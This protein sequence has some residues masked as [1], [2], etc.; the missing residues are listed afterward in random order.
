MT[1]QY[2]T[3]PLTPGDGALMGLSLALTVYGFAIVVAST[4]ADKELVPSTLPAAGLVILA[5]IAV[6]AVVGAAA[7]AMRDRR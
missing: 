4:F 5:L 1:S 7:I 6:G 2:V 3:E